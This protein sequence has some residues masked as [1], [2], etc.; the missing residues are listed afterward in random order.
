MSDTDGGVYKMRIEIPEFTLIALIGPSSSGKTTFAEKHFLRTQV[1]SS[2]AFRRMVSDDETEQSVSGDAFELLFRTA[3]KRL[4]HRKTTVIDATNLQRKDRKRL[5]EL[6]K[7][8]NVHTAAIVLELPREQL[9]KRNNAR[10]DRVLPEPIID[11]Q[12]SA[13]KRSIRCLKKKA[14]VLSMR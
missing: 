14:F 9:L 2:D 1:L 13:L 3:E 5:L 12:I 11:S 6:A 7:A 8:Q 10:E 4:A